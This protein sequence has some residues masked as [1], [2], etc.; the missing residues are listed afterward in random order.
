LREDSEGSV[1]TKP[2]LRKY[3]CAILGLNQCPVETSRYMVLRMLGMSARKYTVKTIAIR[4]S[5]N[6]S[7]DRGSR[8]DRLVE[9]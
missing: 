3:W 8:A 6:A 1:K 5:A 2:H 7:K 9:G 4:K